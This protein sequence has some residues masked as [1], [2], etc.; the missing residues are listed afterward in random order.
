MSKKNFSGSW[1]GVVGVIKPTYRP[2]SLE[3]F[4]RLLPEGI[5]VIPKFVGVSEGLEKE[6]VD[7]FSAAEKMI[8]ELAEMKVDLIHPEGAPLFVQKGYQR[9]EEIVRE[10]VEKYSIPVVTTGMV[11]VE[12]A[13]ALG[14][15]KLL[16]ISSYDDGNSSGRFAKYF[17]YFSD[18][19]FHVQAV[20]G[21]P[22][23]FSD[24]GSVSPREAYAFARKLFLKYS[25]SDGICLIG[26]GWRVLDVVPLLEQDL[27]IPVICAVAARVWAIQKRLRVRQPVKGRGMLLATMP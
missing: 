14:I 23:A 21:F 11:L 7:G 25:H 8:A 27:Q 5:G 13:R 17:S 10:L 1:R 24:I 3:E 18:A 12:A 19:G 26:S 20:E 4:I 2:G 6:F 22:V 16:V 9:S 15:K